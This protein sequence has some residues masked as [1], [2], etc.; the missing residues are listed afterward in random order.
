MYPLSR[1]RGLYCILTKNTWPLIFGKGR[2]VS[3]CLTQRTRL[4]CEFVLAS[5][6]HI[7]HYRDNLQSL[8]C[9][10]DTGSLRWEGPIVIFMYKM[11]KLLPERFD[12]KTCWKVCS[13]IRGQIFPPYKHRVPYPSQGSTIHESFHKRSN[14][15][16]TGKKEL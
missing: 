6:S 3:L 15:V 7:A 2:T 4:E 8:L 13:C 9:L 14:T 1:Q 10:T 16:Q 5:C 11:R 12:L